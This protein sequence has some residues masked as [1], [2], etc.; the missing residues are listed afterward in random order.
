MIENEEK[1]CCDQ[2]GVDLVERDHLHSCIYN[3]KNASAIRTRKLED[4]F[5]RLDEEVKKLAKTTAILMHQIS[6]SCTELKKHERRI[7]A[8]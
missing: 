4:A 8:N 5:K 7:H 3:A 1:V 2:C 6:G